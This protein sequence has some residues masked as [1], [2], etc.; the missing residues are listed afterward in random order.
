M[1]TL[2]RSKKGENSWHTCSFIYDDPDKVKRARDA[3]KTSDPRT[4][5]KVV[6]LT[7]IV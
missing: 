1:Y 6:K 4:E 2:I 7:E 5:Y 3:M